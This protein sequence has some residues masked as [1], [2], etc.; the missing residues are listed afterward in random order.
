[1]KSIP[2]LSMSAPQDNGPIV[3]ILYFLLFNLAISG[4]I[5]LIGELDYET[6]E[7]FNLTVKASDGATDSPKHG[8]AFVIVAVID[9]NDNA[10]V[11]DKSSYSVSL[12]ENATLGSFVIQVNAT[13]PD[14]DV[15]HK[16][17]A[18]KIISGNEGNAF[19]MSGSNGTVSVNP[20]GPGLDREGKDLYKL[21]LVVTSRVNNTELQ[22]DPVTVSENLKIKINK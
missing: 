4:A 12:L 14:K 3:L 15:A 22:S 11:F 2:L 1:M 7:R 13:D 18:Y 6:K 5:T 9:I 21:Q 20:S 16:S 17:V 10:P 19:V 8:F